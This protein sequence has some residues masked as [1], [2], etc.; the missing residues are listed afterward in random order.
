MSAL[1][2]GAPD[3]QAHLGAF[4]Q[5]HP[6]C[7]STFPAELSTPNAE[8]AAESAEFAGA[9]RRFWEMRDG[10]YENQDRLG[11]P[12]LFA[13]VGALGLSEASLR[14]PPSTGPTQRR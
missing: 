10:I 11:L 6:V 12:L 14:K 9:H 1:R 13:L 7:L 4:W 3:R 5:E 2:R 8:A